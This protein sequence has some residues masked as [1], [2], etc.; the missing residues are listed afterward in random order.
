MQYPV[1]GKTLLLNQFLAQLLSASWNQDR[2][3]IHSS[4]TMVSKAIE[5]DQQSIVGLTL[6]DFLM[7]NESNGKES[8]HC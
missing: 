6:I 3:K 2:V 1:Y 7:A 5:S 8:F 4:N